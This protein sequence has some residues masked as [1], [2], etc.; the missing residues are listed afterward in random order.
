MK[1]I[2]SLLP[3]VLIL[4]VIICSITF[5][6]NNRELNKTDKSFT[7]IENGNPHNQPSINFFPNNIGDFWEFIEEDTTTLFSQLLSLKFSVSREVLVDT[8]M[9]NGLTYKKVKWQNEANSVNYLP[10][11]EYLRV[12]SIGNAHI[13]YDTTDYVLFD[14][15]LNVNQTYMAH[16]PDYHWE[17]TDKYNVIGFGDTLQAIDFWLFDQNNNIEEKYSVVENF[18]I[19]YYQIGIQYYGVPEGNFWG[20]VINWQEYGT[21][22]VKKQTV[23]WKQFYPLHIGDYWVYEGSSG[24]FST[25]NTVR[26]MGD[27]LMPDGNTYFVSR[28]IDYHFQYT[29]LNY[30]R[31]DSLGNIYYWEYWNSLPKKYFEFSFIVGDTLNAYFSNFCNYRL[32]D[33]YLFSFGEELHFF[34]YPDLS[35]HSENYTLGIGLV[36][37]TGE[38]TYSYLIGA[39]INGSLVYGDTTLTDIENE[40]ITSLNDYALFQNHPNPFNPSTKISWLSPVGSWQTLKVYDILGNEVATLVNEYRNAGRYEVNFNASKLSSGVYFYQLR[41]GNY[42]ETKKM[43]LLK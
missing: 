24:S 16:I 12:D 1:N 15:T 29:E 38:Q 30:R 35:F 31:I 34:V 5:A 19:I 20:A 4:L 26:I 8:I 2:K 28:L 43:I 42:V 3:K 36:S 39:Y 6:Q 25:L 10:S 18:G 41:A 27:T 17:V 23:D 21:L 11:Y 13:Y 22:I 40:V 14:F 33:K 7:R 37:T 32:D 9:S